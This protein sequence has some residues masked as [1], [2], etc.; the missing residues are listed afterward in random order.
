MWPGS[1][2]LGRDGGRS[3]NL[4]GHSSFSM[5]FT[6]TW[7]F[8][9]YLHTTEFSQYRVEIDFKILSFSYYVWPFSRD[10]SKPS[11]LQTL[12][13]RQ[14]WNYFFKPMFLPKNERI[15]LTLLLVYLFSFVFWKKVK[16]PKRHFEIKW[17]LVGHQKFF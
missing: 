7:T 10:Q 3:E 8:L 9:D 17:P 15:N 13:V 14:I 5:G 6:P 1:L 12:K 4:R 11:G 16:T 2:I